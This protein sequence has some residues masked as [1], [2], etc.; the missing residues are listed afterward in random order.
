[1]GNII[2]YGLDILAI[3]FLIL[4]NGV[5]AMAEIAVVSSRKPRLKALAE[6]QHRGANAALKLAENPDRFLSAGQVGITSVGILAGV[7]GGEELAP[8]VERFLAGFTALAPYSE[9]LAI[10]MIVVSIT[11]VSIVLGELVPKQIALRDPERVASILAPPMARFTAL[12]MPLVYMLG[13][14]SRFFLGFFGASK[15]R[16]PT[17]TEE[18]LKATV[19]EG[20]Q[21]GILAPAEKDMITG[22]LRLGDWHVRALMTPRREIEWIDLEADDQEIRRRLREI[23]YSRLLVAKDTL[24]ELLGIVQAKDLLDQAIAGQPFNLREALRQPLYV[25]G[26][27]PALRVLEMLKA[28]PIHMAVVV[29]ESGN[30]EGI[31]TPTDVLTTI[32]GGLIEPGEESSTP[33]IV[34]REDGSWLIGGDVHIDVIKDLLG[35]RDIIPIEGDF[36]TLAGFMLSRMDKVPVAGDH[37]EWQGIRFEVVDMDGQRIDKVLVVAPALTSLE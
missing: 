11:F 35:V 19:A 3:L 12:A 13:V 16:E 15:I 8:P 20:V 27:M 18:E 33:D 6:Q 2:I 37:F 31:V 36:Y 29:D 21:E 7:F 10:L 14:S 4:L 32:V 22:V 30:L 23:P 17:V 26:H 5:F 1:M 9:A 24:D 34:Q 25:H 28:S